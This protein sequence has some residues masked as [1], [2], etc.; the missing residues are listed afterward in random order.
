[1]PEHGLMMTVRDGC[2]LVSIQKMSWNLGI[3]ILQDRRLTIQGRCNALGLSN[4]T[5]QRILLEELNTMRIAAKFEQRLLQSE[6]KQQR[7]EVCRELQQQLQ[8]DPNFLSKFAT[9]TKGEFMA[10]TLKLSSNRRNG[11][12]RLHLRQ[13]V[14]QVKRN[15]K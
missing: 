11:R 12:A 2:Q 6:Q 3:L 10:T 15:I 14:Q 1:M 9:V 4:G 8:E 13:K 7:L 5:S